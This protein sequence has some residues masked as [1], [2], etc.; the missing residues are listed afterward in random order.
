[1]LSDD[2]V[3]NFGL[4]AGRMYGIDIYIHWF[5][6]ILLAL[7]LLHMSVSDV[8]EGYVK[9]WGK[10]FKIFPAFAIA[11]I[12]SI[13]L[14]E[15]GHALAAARQGGRCDRIVLW[16]LGGL[17]YCEAPDTPWTQFV[18][19]VGGPLV[20]LAL[21]LFGGL[22]CMIAGWPLL[23]Y[24]NAEWGF[25]EILFQ[26]VFL[27]NCLLLFINLLP[28]YPLDGGRML[29]TWMW[30]R[31]G[32][33]QGALLRT[34]GISRVVA[35]VA[36]AFGVVLLFMGFTDKA[37][38]YKH[39]VIDHLDFLLILCGLTYFM[40]AR[41]IREQ[42]MYG[43]MD[44]GGA[45]GYDFSRGYTSLENGDSGA[46]PRPSWSERRREEKAR[47]AEE[48]ESE[49]DRE[50]RA[51]LDELLEKISRD[52]MGSLSSDEKRFLEQA[53]KHLRESEAKRD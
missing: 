46:E 2:S 22:V 7:Q 8:P 9:D 37:W 48:R 40:T 44:D 10:V 36:I 53:S 34:L 50:V 1:M 47:R 31:M 11:L 45:F 5:L 24:T 30:T 28:C 42:V 15:L 6:L 41:Q 18:V 29:H 27:W 32:T 52:G 35:I 51:R 25:F 43:E 17:A 19:A 12:G 20:T 23:P 21:I 39:P 4:R 3:R 13:F 49:K 38:S 14:H 26:Y 33:N 16:P